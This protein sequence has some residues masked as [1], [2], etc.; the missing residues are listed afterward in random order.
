MKH[1][2]VTLLVRGLRIEAQAIEGGVVHLAVRAHQQHQ[3]MFGRLRQHLANALF[4]VADACHPGQNHGPLW[5]VEPVVGAAACQDHLANSA[6]SGVRY[7]WPRHDSLGQAHYNA[8]FV[9]EGVKRHQDGRPV[10]KGFF[11]RGGQERA[12]YAHGAPL[13][14]G[15]KVL[16][17]PDG[18]QR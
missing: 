14:A 4:R 17:W 12:D 2:V 11:G 13:A 9:H 7:I 10:V 3:G 16:V 1:S 8:L 18:Q 15:A 6:E 5:V